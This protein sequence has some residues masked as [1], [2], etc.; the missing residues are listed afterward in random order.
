MS[1]RPLV[2]RV[3]TALDGQAV[4]YALV[5]AAALA[6]HGV[7]RSTFAIDFFTT[8][9]GVLH[10][11]SWNGLSSEGPVRVSVRKGD[12][13]DPLAGIVRLEADGERAVDL[14]VGRSA[15]Q[16]AAL[17]RA[18]RILI[19]GAHLPVVTAAD[20]VLFKLYAGGSQDCWDIEQVLAGPERQAIE[21]TVDARLGP[22]PAAARHLWHRLRSH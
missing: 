17:G 2:V 9:P 11:E 7:A 14:V 6:A 21:A 19:A 18:T 3:A 16:S 13:D 15:W 20:L 4:P 12:A 1:D 5:G 10:R 22:L 8:E